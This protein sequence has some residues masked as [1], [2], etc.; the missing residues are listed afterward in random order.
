MADNDRNSADEGERDPSRV[1]ERGIEPH[2]Y[3]PPPP[4]PP[5][6]PNSGIGDDK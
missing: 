3:V 5:E 6:V 4:P 2:R 1:H